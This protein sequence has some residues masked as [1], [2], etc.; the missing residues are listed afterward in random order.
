MNRFHAALL[1]IGV[2][3]LGVIALNGARGPSSTHVPSKAA[4]RPIMSKSAPD[5]PN[6]F[7]DYYC[8]TVDDR[9]YETT[10]PPIPSS[11]TR[12]G[13]PC[14]FILSGQKRTAMVHVCA[15]NYWHVVAEPCER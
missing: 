15:H 6:P 11:Y 3:F 2:I 10:I 13:E 14:F 1:A 5:T 7:G 8:L 4:T 9:R 12:E